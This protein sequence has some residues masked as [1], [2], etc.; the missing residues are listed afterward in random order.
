[1]KMEIK[2]KTLQEYIWNNIGRI[3]EY[4]VWDWVVVLEHFKLPIKDKNYKLWVKDLKKEGRI[5]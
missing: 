2:E 3:G 1:M 5:E 4:A